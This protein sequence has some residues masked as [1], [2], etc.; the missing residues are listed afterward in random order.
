MSDEAVKRADVQA[1]IRKA[2]QDLR[3][4]ELDLDAEPPLVADAAFHCQQAVE[5]LLKA[6]LTWHET[7]F[8]KTH[9]LGELGLRTAQLIPELEPLLR[10]AAPLSEYAWRYRYPDVDD[11]PQIM[12]VDDAL[13][14]ARQ[15]FE[16]VT[17][18]LPLR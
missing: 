4:A 9:D 3:A 5:K 13:A 8:R 14:L 15:V 17:Q 7:P 12:E 1:W 18:K 10:S 11:E 6:V 2:A 16:A